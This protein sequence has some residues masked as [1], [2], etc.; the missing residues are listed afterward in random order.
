MVVGFLLHDA[1][2]VGVGGVSGERKFGIWG[3]VLKRYRRRHEA[4]GLLEG[5]LSGGG[6]L[7]CFGPPPQEI[8][9]RLQNL[10]T[11]W[12]E[13][14]VKVYHA[15]KTLQLLDVLRGRAVFE[16]GG[17]I[18]RGGRSCRRNRVAKNLKG[19]GCKNTLFQVNPRSATATYTSPIKIYFFRPSNPQSK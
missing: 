12:Q 17:V 16:F 8:R 9:Q 2:D 7:Q 19:G 14:A 1:S 13:A 6:R 3:R 5:L 18:G 15:E 11:I 4:F 10:S